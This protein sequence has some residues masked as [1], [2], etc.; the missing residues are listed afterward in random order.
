MIFLCDSNAA[1]LVAPNSRSRAGGYHYLGNKDESQFNGPVYI[2]AKIINAVIASAAEAEIG[3]L[4][5]NTQELSPMRT[6]LEELDHPQPPTP[7][8][9]DDS[10]ADGIMNKTMKQK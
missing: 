9:K 1:Y 3:A 8:Q 4:Y 2:L 10:T 6:T 7:L 5:I